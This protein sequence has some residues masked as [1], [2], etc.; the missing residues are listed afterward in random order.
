MSKKISGAEYPLSKIFNSDFACMAQLIKSA[1]YP[2][3]YK[4]PARA[5]GYWSVCR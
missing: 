2:A 5:V 4:L 1:G 3:F